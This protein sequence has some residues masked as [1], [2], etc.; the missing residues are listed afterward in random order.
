[1]LDALHDLVH[2]YAVGFG[3]RATV[4]INHC[5]PILRHRG[6]TVHHQMC[7]GNSAMDRLD[8]IHRQN[9]A[10]R[11]PGKFIGAMTRTTGDR[12]RV[13]AG[14]SNEASRLFRIG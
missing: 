11:W 13:Y 8:L 5:Q 4:F 1:M 10:R 14:I 6:G 9:I 2:R 12:Q 3:Y 7:A